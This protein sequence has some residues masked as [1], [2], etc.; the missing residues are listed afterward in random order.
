MRRTEENETLRV[1]IL[2]DI[3]KGQVDINAMHTSLLADISQ[4]LAVIADALT[5]RNAGKK[6]EISKAADEYFDKLI[7]GEFGE[8]GPHATD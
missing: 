8:G 6:D 5:E 1:T 4:S 7:N 3:Q 2:Q